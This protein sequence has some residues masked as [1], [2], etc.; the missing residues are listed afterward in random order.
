MNQEIRLPAPDFR[1]P[2]RQ[3]AKTVSR[4]PQK[5]KEKRQKTKGGPPTPGSRLLQR[6]RKN[7][8][9]GFWPLGLAFG[10]GFWVWVLGLGFGFGFWVLGLGFGFGFWVW[11]L[12]FG[13]GFWV[14]VLGLGL[15]PP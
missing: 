14:W 3:K 7:Q 15:G 8:T 5:K 10:F 4:L 13:F 6:Q 1:L 9:S 11:V 2:Q 12:G